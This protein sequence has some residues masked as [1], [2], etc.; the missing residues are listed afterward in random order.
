[1]KKIVLGVAAMVCGIALAEDSYLYWQINQDGAEKQIE[2][3]FAQV[4]AT[5]DGSGDFYIVGEAMGVEGF[6]EG[7]TATSA[8]PIDSA[9]NMSAY[10]EDAGYSFV[11]ELMN[12]DFGVIGESETFFYADIAPYIYRSMGQ[13]GEA[14][15]TDTTFN[16]VPEPTSGMLLLLG[17]A[18]LAL[19]RRKNV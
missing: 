5:K 19:K 17:V 8:G 12:S 14:A 3:A 10:G 15:W 9:F 18:G 13:T 4:K 11:V 16:S 2:F 6:A 1:M 7:K